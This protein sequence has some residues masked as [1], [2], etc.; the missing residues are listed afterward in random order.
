[1]TCGSAPGSSLEEHAGRLKT[2]C[3]KALEVL[4][5]AC[6][7]CHA[8]EQASLPGRLGGLFCGWAASFM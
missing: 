2:E 5:G 4:M 8:K 1:M 3:L 6:M 7:V